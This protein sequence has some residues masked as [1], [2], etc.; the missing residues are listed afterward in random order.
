[1]HLWAESF[2]RAYLDPYETQR[3]IANAL[4]AAIDVVVTNLDQSIILPKPT[5]NLNAW[6]AYERGLWHFAQCGMKEN[7]HARHF[8]RHAM[9]LD[10]HLS[11]AYQWL[12]YVHVQ[13]GIHYRTV[14]VEK[15]CAAA[16]E[17][18]MKAIEL[19]P[20]DAGSYAA[21]GF[22]A[23]ISN[24][25]TVGLANA[26]RA[27][28]LNPNDGDAL[29]LKGACQLGLGMST[30]GAEVLR[31]SVR[32]RPG[33]PL[34]WRVPHHLCWHSYLVG[35][36]GAAAKAGRAALRANAKQC[37]THAW[38]AAALAQLG[39]MDAAKEVIARAADAI[40]PL[41]FNEHVQRPLPWVSE[42]GHAR[43][44]EGLRKAGWSR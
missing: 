29:R 10:P 25:L 12:V 13:D 23:Q 11:K 40:A 20:N 19:D 21:A 16:N 8:L 37:L 35:D 43:M 14:P 6:E 41:S 15:A 39:Q 24:D 31:M 44:L 32:L 36:W 4:A 2:N 7:E 1:M 17:L 42:E 3:E 38:L 26:E 30:E 5:D 18:A 9:T 34:N 22:A 27:L 28:S 33:D